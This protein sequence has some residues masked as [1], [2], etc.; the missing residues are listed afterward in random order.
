MDGVRA[1]GGD[2]GMGAG[3]YGH[4][5]WQNTRTIDS[6]SGADTEGVQEVHCPVGGA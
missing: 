3:H 4:A 6:G 5:R 2:A 1:A